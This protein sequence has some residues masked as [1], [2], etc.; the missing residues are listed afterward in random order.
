MM[1]AA[2]S[3]SRIFYSMCATFLGRMGLSG[4]I[5]DLSDHQWELVDSAMTFYKKA[6]PII[7]DGKTTVIESEPYLYNDPEGCQLVVRERRD[8]KL[9]VFHRFK[10]SCSYE[11]YLRKLGLDFSGCKVLDSYGSAGED[12]SAM[13]MIVRS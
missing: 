2:D 4:D 3:D 7:R 13:A 8:E 11:D 1:R 9:I 10:G 12:F 6:A 5:Y